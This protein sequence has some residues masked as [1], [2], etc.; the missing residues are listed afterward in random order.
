MKVKIFSILLMLTTSIYAAMVDGVSLI[1]N[2]EP[3]TLFE[4]HEFSKRFN[5]STDE[6][7]D[8]LIQKKIEDSEIKANQIMV[9]DYEVSQEMERIAQNNNL[10]LAEFEN[11]I[12]EKGLSPLNYKEDLKEK[13]KK[14]KLYKKIASQK[15]RRA[16]DDELERY[17]NVHLNEFSIP[18]RVEVTEYSSNSRDALARLHKNPMLKLASIQSS[19]KVM[20]TSGMHPKLVFILN[21]TKEN[22]FSPI[23]N[24]G[25][26]YVTLFVKRKLNVRSLPFEQVK[27]SVFAKVMAEKEK[28]V[29]IEHFEKIKAEADINVIRRPK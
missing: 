18:E 28:A 8:I 24:A 25:D 7:V 21:E 11:L 22:A 1:V 4:I 5:V 20:P 12:R 29:I 23:L 26:Q 15:I 3:V 2:N 16:T 9:N 13:L 27:Q 6:A 10:S 17:Y 14:D 19:E